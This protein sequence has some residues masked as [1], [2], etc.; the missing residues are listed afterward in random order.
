[1]PLAACGAALAVLAAPWSVFWWYFGDAAALA[2]TWSVFL[3]KR[4]ETP[5]L[6]YAAGAGLAA[7]WL[8]LA[9]DYAS[10]IRGRGYVASGLRV[11]G[12]GAAWALIIGGILP[13]VI[14]GDAFQ[15]A[16]VRVPPVYD[17]WLIL[18]LA[19]AARFAVLPMAL[20]RVTAR[21][22][23][24]PCS[25]MAALDGASWWQTCRHVRWPLA[26]DALALGVA[27]VILLSLTDVAVTQ[28]L[29]PPRVG[30]IALTMLNQI[31]FGR[32][33]DVIALAFYL[34]GAVA[35]A[36]G[37]VLLAQSVARRFRQGD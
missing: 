13:P 7:C 37:A 28:S 22:R 15:A 2:R 27:L 35:V 30:N 32:N 8:A 16:Y 3:L 4:G 9:I 17:T 23:C 14:M 19:L 29:T 11:A 24:G 26:R 36:V 18:S 6:L 20:M 34:G 33:D 31:H 25:D 21:T 5:A 1:M 10:S 12:W